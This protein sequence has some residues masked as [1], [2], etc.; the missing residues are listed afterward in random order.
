[1]GTGGGGFA[2]PPACMLK[3]A[4]P[5][6]CLHNLYFFDKHAYKYTNLQN[7]SKSVHSQNNVV[8]YVTGPSLGSDRRLHADLVVMFFTLPGLVT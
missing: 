1:M 4:L 2:P 3:K 7:I 6:L 5:K 8:S